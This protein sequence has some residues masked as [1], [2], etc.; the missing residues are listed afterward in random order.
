MPFGNLNGLAFGL[1]GFLPI[2]FLPG[3]SF[4]PVEVEVEVLVHF[5]GF[6]LLNLAAHLTQNFFSI[7]LVSDL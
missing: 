6:H 3:L 1:V 2:L 7:F 4:L 5:V